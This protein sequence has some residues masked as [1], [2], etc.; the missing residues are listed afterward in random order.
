MVD[1]QRS[2][3]GLTEKTGTIVIPDKTFNA[4]GNG[5][6]PDIPDIGFYL[7]CIN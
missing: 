4:L 2:H 7:A 6:I 5:F 1:L 3:S